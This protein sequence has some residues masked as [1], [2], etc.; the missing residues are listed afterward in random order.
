MGDGW[1]GDGWVMGPKNVLR[2]RSKFVQM[3]FR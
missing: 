1:M 3:K 2:F